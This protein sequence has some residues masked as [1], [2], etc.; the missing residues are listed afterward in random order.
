MA[1]EVRFSKDARESMLRGVNTL[2]NAV[3][4]TLFFRNCLLS[5]FRFPRLLDV[6]GKQTLA[7]SS[8]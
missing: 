1:K 5:L 8:V 7:M 3:R 2:A 4:V 6:N